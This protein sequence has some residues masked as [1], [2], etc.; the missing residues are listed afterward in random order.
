LEGPRHRHGCGMVLEHHLCARKRILNVELIRIFL[1]YLYKWQQILQ[2]LS[3]LFQKLLKNPQIF[4]K[5]S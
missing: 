4:Q 5:N 2:K 1:E 3:Q